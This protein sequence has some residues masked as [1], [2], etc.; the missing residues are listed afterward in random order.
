MCCVK[1]SMHSSA[2]DG[3]KAGGLSKGYRNGVYRRDLVTSSGRIE[4]LK[5]PRDREGHFHTQVFGRYIRDVPTLRKDA[6]G[7]FVAE[8]STHKVG[9]VAQTLLGVAPNGS[10]GQSPQ[11]T[12]ERDHHAIPGLVL[13]VVDL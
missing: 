6:A 1:S 7:M 4:D 2:W 3:E 13:Q 8:V 5:V 10:R 12:G 9:E 11:P